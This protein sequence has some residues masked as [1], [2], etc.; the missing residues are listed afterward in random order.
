MPDKRDKAGCNQRVSCASRVPNR[1]SRVPCAPQESRASR[2]VCV[3]D[4]R[5]ACVLPAPHVAKPGPK[6]ARQFMPFAALKGFYELVSEK[7][8]EAARE[9]TLHVARLR[10]Y[11]GTS[12]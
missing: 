4:S 6:R 1:A 11:K 7:E 2:A 9:P 5:A 10:T 8:A 3:Q 12:T